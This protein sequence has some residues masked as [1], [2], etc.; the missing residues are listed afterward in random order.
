[1]NETNVVPVEE[2]RDIGIVT[3]EINVLVNQYKSLTVA[4]AVEIGRRLHEA[5]SLLDHGEWGT[6]L[7]EKVNFSQRTANNLM[8][9]CDEYADA[10][11]TLFGA[12]PKS[13]ALANL[14]LTKAIRLLALDEDERE[15]FVG[16][17]DVDAMT[18]RELEAAIAEKKNAEAHAEELVQKVQELKKIADQRQQEKIDLAKK[19]KDAESK[20]KD[21][22][23]TAEESYKKK[24]AESWEKS[25]Q[26][27]KTAEE[28]RL[29][30]E[31]EARRL[32]EELTAAKQA[33]QLQ[34]PD[35]AA[36]KTMFEQTQDD[37][38]KLYTILGR[39]E[40]RAPETAE[41]LK[42]ALHAL[43]GQIGGDG[44]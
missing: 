16:E 29:A 6:W 44:K 18:T 41:K 2:V 43:A 12:V 10:Q 39:I 7:K 4:Y 22:G 31:S 11:I 17:H 35:V 33:R 32:T 15:E 20:A 25:E 5:K 27:V 24:L 30:A 34:D 14:S 8:R 42:A 3:S 19:L 13:Q 26:A 1:M 36:F 40:E 23:K 38:G 9:V 21:A 28:K 37:I